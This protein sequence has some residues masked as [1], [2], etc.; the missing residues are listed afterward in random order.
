MDR[1]RQELV[2]TVRVLESVLDKLNL[3]IINLAMAGEY[4]DFDA[5]FE[6]G[7][8]M[9]FDTDDFR[10]IEDQNVKMSIELFDKIYSSYASIMNINA[11][12]RDEIDRKDDETKSDAD[13]L[14]F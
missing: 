3:N 13:D 6:V 11:L 10:N 14:P 9:K 1:Y 4:S 7:E 2:C 5:Q 8:T 12:K